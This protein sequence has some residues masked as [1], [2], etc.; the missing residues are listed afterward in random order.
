MTS[1]EKTSTISEFISVGK[2]VNMTYYNSSI[3]E[4]INNI[5]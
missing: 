5:E 4:K 1:P 2:N 3:V